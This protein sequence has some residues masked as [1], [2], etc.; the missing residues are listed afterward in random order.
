ME[1]AAKIIESI[2]SLISRGTL[3]WQRPW[4][5]PGLGMWPRNAVTGR[6]YTGL[7]TW[8]LMLSGY[9]LPMWV[10][11]DGARKAGGHVRK[12]E[13]GTQILRPLF[14]RADCASAGCTVTGCVDKHERL[15]GFGSMTVWNIAQ[16]G[17][18]EHLIPKE[19]EVTLHK[20][21]VACEEIVRDYLIRENS[22]IIIHGGE[23]AA[24]SPALHQIYMP[25]MG[26]FDT[27]ESYY[28]TLFHEMVHSTHADLGRELKGWQSEDYSREELVA[29]FGAAILCG[30]A[31]IANDSLQ[32]LSASYLSTW[33]Q[34]I[35][36]EPAAL[37]VGASR[38][39]KA[40]RLIL[41]DRWK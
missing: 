9:P 33:A 30:F 3:P 32:S 15:Y 16:T 14:R 37:Q 41:G 20:P 40:A 13:R 23:R 29:E 5:S 1:L 22:P 39:E 11:Y 36:D 6:H 7:N 38:G 10:T 2:L 34:R 18:L 26:L 4:K 17:G 21:L 12:G 28:S 19:P 35:K 25:E 31:G 24:Y 8:L 27:A